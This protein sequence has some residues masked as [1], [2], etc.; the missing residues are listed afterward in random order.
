MQTPAFILQFVQHWFS[1]TKK[2]SQHVKRELSP[3]KSLSLANRV[4]LKI[5][6]AA[7]QTP[8]VASDEPNKVL[9]K[10]LRIVHLPEKSGIGRI[11]ISGRMADV[12]AE[13]DRLAALEAA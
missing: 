8:T 10:P 13:L 11:R 12:C 2:Q 6:I 7:Q 1:N 5:N 9:Q 3:H 4:D